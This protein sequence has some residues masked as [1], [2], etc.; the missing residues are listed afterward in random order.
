METVDRL[1]YM[2]DNMLFVNQEDTIALSDAISQLEEYQMF[3]DLYQARL[4][5][6][7]VAMLTEV[8]NSIDVLRTRPDVLT[9]DD[10]QDLLIECIGYIEEKI[11]A[12][13]GNE[14]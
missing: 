11:N 9:D 14:K 13:R 6:D 10:K 2:H 4:N 7:M 5:I 3:K 12:L 1:K 8:K